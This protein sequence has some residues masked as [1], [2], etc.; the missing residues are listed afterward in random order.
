[1]EVEGSIC[2]R[3]Y[4]KDG[5]SR[6]VLEVRGTIYNLR[7]RP[8]VSPV[9]AQH[10]VYDG[11]RQARTGAAPS[12]SGRPRRLHQAPPLAASDQ[13][14]PKPRSFFPGAGRELSTKGAVLMKTKNKIDLIGFVGTDPETHQTKEGTPVTR[15]SLATTER[16]KDKDEQLQ[17]HTEWHRI[18]FFGVPATQ[19]GEFV[20]K[21]SLLEVEGSVRSRSYEK[22]GVTR[23]AYEV[24]G[25]EYRLLD[26]HP[27]SDEESASAPEMPP[28]APAADQGLPL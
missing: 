21:G 1:V 6:A 5:V 4:E 7:D 24:R 15:F 18:V 28:D 23:T 10:S 19:L 26:R 20:R 12:S 8:Y 14:E 3:T 11:S 17:Q 27:G 9:R 25:T 22:D 13:G 2:S 16:W